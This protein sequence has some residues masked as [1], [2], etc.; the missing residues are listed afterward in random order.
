M[1]YGQSRLG[2]GPARASVAFMICGL[3]M[4]ALQVAAAGALSKVAAPTVQVAAGFVVMGI[5]IAAIVITRDFAVVLGVVAL[6][7]AGSAVVTPNLSALVSAGRGDHAGAALGMKSTA[8]SVGQF[9]GPG[10]S[11]PAQLAA[12]LSLRARR[13]PA[14]D[15]RRRGRH[16]A[17]DEARPRPWSRRAERSLRLTAEHPKAFSTTLNSR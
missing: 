9:V 2:I 8:T 6:L 1:L 16:P 3:V 15:A 17:L 10:R 5:G 13:R 4:A 11:R 12:R 7:A 14:R